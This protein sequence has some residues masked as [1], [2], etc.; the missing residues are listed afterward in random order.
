[1]NESQLETRSNI[2]FTPNQFH[3]SFV[4]LWSQCVA[5]WMMALFE[6]KKSRALVMI[7]LSAVA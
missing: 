5:Y 3:S 4:V 1:M 2:L 7:A 6:I